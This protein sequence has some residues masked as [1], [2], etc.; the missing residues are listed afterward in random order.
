ML[1]LSRLSA[2]QRQIVL[3]PPGPLAIIAG[4]GSGKT[5]VLAARIAAL[6]TL[7][8]VTPTTVLALTFT[9]AAAQTLR[10]RLQG[11]LGDRAAPI[12][13]QTFHALGLRIIRQWSAELGFGPSPP[14]VY[15]ERDAQN[16][17]RDAIAAVRVPP[18]DSLTELA[19]RLERHRLKAEVEGSDA[20]AAL[21]QTY[22]DLLRRRNAVDYP[23]MLVLP[24]RLF[25]THPPAL[26]VL[27]DSYQAIFCDEAQDIC[28]SQYALLRQLAARHHHLVLVGDPRQSLYG[29]R[30]GD[31]R[32]LRDLPRDFPRARVLRLD[33]NFRSTQRIVQVANVLGATLG[34]PRPLWTA[35]P[36]GDPAFLYAARDEPDEA[37]FVASEIGRLLSSGVIAHPGEVAVL[38]RTKRQTA[39]L[40]LALRTR[41]LPY[42]TRG[43]T[44]LVARRE[45]RDALAYLR[46]VHH[47]SDPAALARIANLPPRHLGWLKRM[48][49]PTHLEDLTHLAA[50][51]GPDAAAGAAALADLITDL[52]ARRDTLDAPA[53]LD[54]VLE[55]SGYCAWLAGQSEGTVRLAS[56]GL[57]RRLV[58][59][60]A[61]DPTYRDPS[62][63]LA[64]LTTGDVE[65]AAPDDARRILLATIH[66]AKGDEARVVFVVGVEEGLLPHA[67]A[68]ESDAAEGLVAEGQVAY[69]AV[70]RARERL[71]LSWCQARRHGNGSVARR[72]SRFLRGLPLAA[73][74]RVA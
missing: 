8:H 37:R 11:I 2:E 56:L 64:A 6:I 14:M 33:Q 43:S 19:H 45:V 10:A 30:G 67:K 48:R 4:P 9:T 66:Q 50:G 26:R 71:Y 69:V 41:R 7:G 1:D 44:D 31:S 55:R 32:F 62:D 72:P 3:A 74:T 13:V 27:Q 12:A 38:G 39:E 36:P 16:L 25:T 47:P 68:L 18:G 22:E 23:G 63:L 58:A 42:R 5:T 34:E 52:H 51:H 53:L 28:V 59:Q 21:V 29:W 70:T 17:V 24:L 15:G 20:F 49:S 73:T 61:I 40:I 57:L 54:E 65:A 46:L 60:L 35:N